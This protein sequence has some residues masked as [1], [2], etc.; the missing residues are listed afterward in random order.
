[1]KQYTDTERVDW[2]EQNDYPCFERW[3]SGWGLLI[4]EH[5]TLREAI[6]YEMRSPELA[7]QPEK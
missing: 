1:M 2:L 4:H 7:P 3:S 6:D 5:D